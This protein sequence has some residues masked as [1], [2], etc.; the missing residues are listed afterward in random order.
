MSYTVCHSDPQDDRECILGLWRQ[1]LPDASADRYDW[2]Y[3]AGPATSWLVRSAAGEAVGATGLMGRN[4]KVFDRMVRA[5]QAIDLNVDKE[6]RTI[7]PALGLQRALTDAVRRRQLDLVYS[8]PNAQSELVQRRAGFQELGRLGRWAKPLRIGEG[9]RARLRRKPGGKLAA[10]LARPLLWLRSPE[11]FY[12]RPAKLQAWVTDR[13]DA[14]FDR[15]W[16]TASRRFAIVGE[17]TSEYLSWRFCQCPD[18][19]YRVLCLADTDQRLLAYLVYHCRNGMAHVGDFF[20]ADTCYL[21]PLLAE[22]LRMIRPEQA[23]A[24]IVVY[25][26]SSEVC[27]RLKRFGFWPRPSDRNAIVYADEEILGCDTASLLDKENWHLT[28]ADIDADV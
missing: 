16:E 20:F 23:E 27:A 21:E 11:L 15:L 26:G 8:F 10:A 28:Q 3:E 22:F 9:L 7:G 4:M 25:L 6:H 12:R 2:L 13:F 5:G 1:N 18:A 17:R 14:R 24:V 19:C